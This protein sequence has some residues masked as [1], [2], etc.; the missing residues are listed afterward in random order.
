M[1]ELKIFWIL[2]EGKVLL[3]EGNARYVQVPPLKAKTK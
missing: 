2:M 3:K 1:K